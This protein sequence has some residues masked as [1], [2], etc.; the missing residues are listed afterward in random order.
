MLRTLAALPG[1]PSQA[2]IVAGWPLLSAVVIL[3]RNQPMWTAMPIPNLCTVNTN[4]VRRLAAAA[5]CFLACHSSN[6]EAPF[7]WVDP[8]TGYRIFRLSRE[9]AEA[10]SFYFHNNP[11]LAGRDNG[12]DLMVF[13]GTKNKGDVPQL[14]VLDLATL[15]SRE[16]TEESGRI[17]GEIVSPVTRRAYYQVGTRVYSVDVDTGDKDLVVE[18]PEELAGS[19][20]TVNTDASLLLGVHAEGIRELYEKYPTK[21]EYFNVIYEA[22]LPN[23]QFTID[24]H[25]GELKVVHE[26]SAWLNHQQFSPTNPDLLSY[27]HEGPWHKVQ[28][29]WLLDLKTGQSTKIH[30]RTVD[31]EIAGHEFW[32]PDG[33]ILWF[34]LQIPRG[35][36]FY[37]A[38]YRLGTGEE[39]RYALERNEWS[40]HYNISPDQ[41]LFCGD[42]GA[43]R[44]VASSPDGH[45]IYL[46]KPEGDRL[47]STR[48]VNLAKHDYALE[49]NTHFTPDGR[50]IV[51][52]SNLHG[53][54]QIYAVDLSSGKQ[55]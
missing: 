4:H 12:A 25:S 53:A 33:T 36:T 40:V 41:T 6:A 11:F 45:W 24:L 18:L 47:H 21:S 32:S 16:L 37:L 29:M 23:K 8:D 5:G 43:A 3:H 28:R 50:W 20:R 22:R 9:H 52:R 30:E 42:G 7:E 17:R 27:C 14:C 39:T 34:D 55:R 54:A 15:K 48:L 51:F 19:I 13:Y 26:E 38:G 1:R 2:G 49:P 35:E 10:R 44:S 31:R 46:F